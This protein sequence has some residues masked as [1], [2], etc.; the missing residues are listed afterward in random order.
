MA[1]RSGRW[2]SPLVP[3]TLLC[4]VWIAARLHGPAR[5]PPV[6][7]PGP[8]Q[9]GS[10]AQRGRGG[11]R[12][13]LD[14]RGPAAELL[15][16]GA[17]LP[18]GPGLGTGSPRGRMPRP[19]SPLT[20]RPP[21]SPLLSSWA[22]PRA[23]GRLCGACPCPGHSAEAILAASGRVRAS[24]V[25]AP[26]G[27]VA[28]TTQRA[29]HASASAQV[30]ALHVRALTG[31][32]QA[33]VRTVSKAGTVPDSPSRPADRAGSSRADVRRQRSRRSRRA[34]RPAGGVG[35][36]T[37]VSVPVS[38]HSSAEGT[39]P[40]I[41]QRVGGRRGRDGVTHRRIAS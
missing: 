22:P 38:R 41:C 1:A 20:P 8:W 32:Q 18:R 11:R 39:F 36:C 34:G 4:S 27:H 29:S 3:P 5:D 13:G 40:W 24:W 37:S 17:A 19:P 15:S 31:P 10:P 2:A 14:V 12:E 35:A 7:A 6:P 26:C 25:P 30:R 21:P 28:V 9:V 16:D 23:A 33:E